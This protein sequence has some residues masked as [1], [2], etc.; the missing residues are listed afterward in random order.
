MQP[1]P[2]LFENWDVLVVEDE[3]DSLEVAR[4]MLKLAGANVFTATNGRDALELIETIKPRFILS[5][6]SMPVMDGWELLYELKRNRRTLDTPVIALTAHSMPGD[7]DRAITAGFHNYISKP[8]DPPKFIQQLMN[9]LIDIPNSG[10]ST[11]QNPDKPKSEAATEP[12]E[13]AN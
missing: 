12:V 4:R 7:R 10:V 8:L 9:I 13:R 11:D 6:L 3:L 1:V 5:D 2:R